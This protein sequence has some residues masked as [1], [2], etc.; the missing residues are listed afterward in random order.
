MT[1]QITIQN[2]AIQN[3]A[4]RT[5]TLENWLKKQF[6]LSCIEIIPIKNDASFRQYYRCTING[7]S[8]VV[9]DAPPDKENILQFLKITNIFGQTDILVPE[10]IAY[11]LE[12]G[13]MVLSDFGDTW[14]LTMLL[15]TLKNATQAQTSTQI[16]TQISTW[17]HSAI[18]SLIQIQKISSD[19]LEVPF[20]NADHI[21]LEL[22][23]FSEWFVSKL[24]K[25]SLSQAQ[26]EI[27]HKTQNLLIQSAT[28]E[29]Q[30]M[31]HRDYHSRNLM[32]LQNQ[33]L[34]I[35]DY[36]DAMIG[37][38]SY[39]L[40]S[41]LKDCYIVWPKAQIES[42]LQYY[43]KKIS[44]ER[45]MSSSFS[46]FKKSFE[47]IGL[48]RHLKVLGVFSRLN[49]RDN[50]PHYLDD[51]PRIIQYVVSVISE[52][53]ELS[54]FHDLFVQD[55]IPAFAQYQSLRLESVCVQ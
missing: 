4:I 45:L 8:Y 35:I 18:D 22:S 36:Q 53:P 9:M 6:S 25:L 12:Q 31:I 39:D 33:T 34:G 26:L 49:L 46:D 52:Y 17:Y 38:M 24:L 11:D 30:V 43:Y 10:I 16:S 28:D 29:P 50:K 41:L 13:F 47:L 14:L 54:G 3:K 2:N 27:I 32:V 48:Q 20:F 40:A 5:D 21:K 15:T 19:G 1:Y 55:I 7:S 44:S 42:W 23:Y 37:P 51:I